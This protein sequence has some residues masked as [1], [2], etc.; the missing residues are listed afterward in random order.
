MATTK[1]KQRGTDKKKPTKVRYYEVSAP[2]ERD[3][4]TF[5]RQCGA[6]FPSKT[7]VGFT[8]VLD[9][10]PVGNQ[11]GGGCKLIARPPRPKDTDVPAKG[12]RRAERDESEDEADEDMEDE[13]DESE[14][15]ED[16]A[17]DL[18]T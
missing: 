3:G 14:D 6:A 9:T 11:E 15:D 17:D 8:I 1:K 5:W 4:D 12:K 13:A 16:G 7:G 2:I 10:I 18:L